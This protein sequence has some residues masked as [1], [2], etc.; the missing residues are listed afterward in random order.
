MA[1]DNETHEIEGKIQHRTAKSY[2]IETTLPYGGYY[3]FFLPKKCCLDYNP[4]DGDGNMMFLV[5]NW[6]YNKINAG[7]FH[8]D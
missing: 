4:T 7:E 1:W 5:N 3:R 2:I 6:W 8:A